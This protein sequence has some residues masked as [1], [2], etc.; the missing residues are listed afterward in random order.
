MVRNFFFHLSKL[1]NLL[2][3]FFRS[4]SFRPSKKKHQ[5]FK[6]SK[7]I[8]Q[9]SKCRA[10]TAFQYQNKAAIHTQSVFLYIHAISSAFQS[11]FVDHRVNHFQHLAANIAQHAT[12]IVNGTNNIL[13]IV[14]LNVLNAE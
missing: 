1:W 3:N 11:I 14:Y 8:I 12:T 2:E 7:K 9:H 10:T 4:F 13:K 5:N 6:F